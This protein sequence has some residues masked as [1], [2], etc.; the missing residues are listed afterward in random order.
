MRS[1]ALGTQG[2]EVSAIGLGCGG[3][4]NV[5]GTAG[6][7]G[8]EGAV[9]RAFEL[10]ITLFDMADVYGDGQ[11]E[12]LVGRV[13]DDYRDQVS[14]AS[15]AG[16]VGSGD[17]RDFTVDGSPDHLREAC[18]GSLRRLGTDRIDLYYLHRPDPKI[19]IEESV[20]AMAELVAEGKVRFLGLCEASAD[21]VK[22]AHAVHPISALQSEW[23]LW[24][25]DVED[26]VLDVVRRLGIGVVPYAPLGRGFLT[27][28]VTDPASFERQDVR[29]L[30]P[31]FDAGNFERN[32]VLLR[33]LEGFA[34]GFGIGVAQ[35][36]LAWIL[37]LGSDVVPIP[38]TKDP[39]KVTANV[40]AVD[41][42]LSDADVARLARLIP[43]EA[44]AGARYDGATGVE[45]YAITP[46]PAS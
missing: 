43:R 8:P 46:L 31:R 14:L 34:D 23:S 37:A 9:R 30:H 4:S 38:G 19:P 25:R 44:W 24:C 18:E 13:L 28:T 3:L 32:R 12:R 39:A 11:T 2:L 33:E 45:G 35:L 27:G 1:R 22:R 40:A 10:G 7:Q 29:R 5:Y 15:K 26:E 42:A 20:G 17:G 21:T 6:E 41:V 16:L 36:A